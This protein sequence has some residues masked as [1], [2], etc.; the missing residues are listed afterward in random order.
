MLL[1]ATASSSNMIAVENDVYHYDAAFVRKRLAGET[2]IGYSNDT[3]N[4]LAD[5]TAKTW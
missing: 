3:V 2:P 1:G 4:K 5:V